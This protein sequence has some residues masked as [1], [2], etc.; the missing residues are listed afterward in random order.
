[1]QRAD[2]GLFFLLASDEQHGFPVV[3]LF[4][5]LLAVFPTVFLSPV[6]HTV[7][8]TGEI[9]VLETKDC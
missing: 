6:P 7:I 9:N 8:T 1:M 2:I 5:G 3:F 4:H